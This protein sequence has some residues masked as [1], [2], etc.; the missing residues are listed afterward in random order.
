MI[1]DTSKEVFS[2]L[3][4]IN[5]WKDNHTKATTTD[6]IR[7]FLKDATRTGMYFSGANSV[8]ILKNGKMHNA[9]GPA[10]ITMYPHIK[11][12]AGRDYYLDGERV[13]NE[14]IVRRMLE[15][16][17]KLNSREMVWI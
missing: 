17:N 16:R 9:S 3:D 12:P 6:Y 15:N 11:K 7:N 14:D 2:E 4:M 13:P 8:I 10:F 1:C 5:F